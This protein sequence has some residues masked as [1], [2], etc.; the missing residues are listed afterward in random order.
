MFS[1]QI[2]LFLRFLEAIIDFVQRAQSTNGPVGTTPAT[3]ITTQSPQP[4]PITSQQQ[5]PPSESGATTD[6]NWNSHQQDQ[7]FGYNVAS[8]Q[9]Q[10]AAGAATGVSPQQIQAAYKERQVTVAPLTGR[11]SESG[12]KNGP[13]LMSQYESVYNFKNTA[14]E[15]VDQS[16][17]RTS[18]NENYNKQV[19]LNYDG[20][21]RR[22][23]DQVPKKQKLLTSAEVDEIKKYYERKYASG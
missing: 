22:Y 17:G 19:I 5:T 1:L 20:G 3:T 18:G 11:A 12:L 7:P 15:F 8:Q 4:I 16:K 23:S 9:P 6:Q 13:S 10:I 2:R 21:E 14:P